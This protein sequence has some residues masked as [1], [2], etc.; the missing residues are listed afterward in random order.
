MNHTI[1]L[2]LGTN[3]GDRSANLRAALNALPPEVKVITE[4]K[5]HET[6][7]WGYVD[8]P[9]FLNMVIQGETSLTPEALLKYLK[10]LE[11][12]L[13][14]VQSFRWGPRLIDIDLLFYDDLILETDSLS[15]P[16]PRLHQ[17]AFVL[18]PLVEIAPDL[19]HPVLK[20]SIRTLQAR[21]EQQNGKSPA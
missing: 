8:Q 16:H 15:V 4:S 12:Q 5:V 11:Q 14:R 9:A 1:Y 20:E 6:P 19:I 3:L 10:Q 17:R 7:P 13:G 2:A 18:D 21:L